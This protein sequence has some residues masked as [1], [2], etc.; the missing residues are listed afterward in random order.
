MVDRQDF[1]DILECISYNKA[2]DML[3]IIIVASMLKQRRQQ[4]VKENWFLLIVVVSESNLWDSVDIDVWCN[5]IYDIYLSIWAVV[6]SPSTSD[7]R[8]VLIHGY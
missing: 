7:S 5:L 2:V 3:V 4:E 6:D 1:Y 8:S